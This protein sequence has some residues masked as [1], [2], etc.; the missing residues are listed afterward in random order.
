MRSLSAYV[1]GVTSE[2]GRLD[3]AEN[4]VRSRFWISSARGWARA[5][6]CGFDQLGVSSAPLSGHYT[7]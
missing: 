5:C 3:G 4:I 2:T 6:N 7:D 1:R